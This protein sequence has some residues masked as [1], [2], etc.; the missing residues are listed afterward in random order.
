MK[1]VHVGL[2]CDDDHEVIC[3]GE[4]PCVVVEHE[5]EHGHEH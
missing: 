5:P 4:Q 2:E 1:A 3:D